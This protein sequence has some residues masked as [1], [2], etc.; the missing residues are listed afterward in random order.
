MCAEARL[1]SLFNLPYNSESAQ[2]KQQGFV[3]RKL[4]VMSPASAVSILLIDWVVDGLDIFVDAVD[5]SEHST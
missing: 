4:D 5:S 1:A 3:E 2:K